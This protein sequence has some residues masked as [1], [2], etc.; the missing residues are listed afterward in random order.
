[1]TFKYEIRRYLMEMFLLL[2]SV[3]LYAQ[4]PQAAAPAST[5]VGSI[6]G[7]VKSGN[8]PM[9]GVTV[10]ASN[11]L[12]GQ[13]VTTWTDVDGNYFLDV[14]ANGRYVIRTQMAAFANA[15]HEVLINA[16]AKDQKVDL[17]LILL[18][19]VPPA[20]AND[21][22]SQQAQQIAQ[23]M[24]GRGFQNLQVTQG[25]EYTS[26]ANGDQSAG[27]DRKSTRLNSSHIPLSRMP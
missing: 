2:L 16:T 15:T 9:P 24:A 23:A 11:T 6:H 8:M 21:Q 26:A 3:A 22:I 12:T 18:S 4:T 10:T 27:S 25:A 17:E 1:M 13:K 20:P 7:L 19:R 5:P 14:P